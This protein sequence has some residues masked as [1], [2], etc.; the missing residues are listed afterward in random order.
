MSIH[1][2]DGRLEMLEPGLFRTGLGDGDDVYAKRPPPQ[3]PSVQVDIGS[4]PQAS[5]LVPI[6]RPSRSAVTGRAPRF[7]FNKND[8]VT[9]LGNQVEFAEPTVP[10]SI[11]YSIAVLE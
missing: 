3:S 6:D 2:A 7:D 4:V 9:L 5:G 1:L 8:L 10:T 11:Q